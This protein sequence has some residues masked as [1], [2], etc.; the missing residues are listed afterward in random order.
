MAEGAD[1]ARPTLEPVRCSGLLAGLDP[2]LALT[3]LT[4]L[5]PITLL[6]FAAQPEA[7]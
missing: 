6:P 1:T 5:I 2:V 7:Q 3:D 4:P